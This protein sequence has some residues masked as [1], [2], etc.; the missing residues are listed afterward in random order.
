MTNILGVITEINLYGLRLFIIRSYEFLFRLN[1]CINWL[2]IH[3]KDCLYQKACRFIFTM[4]TI[5]A[6]KSPKFLYKNQNIFGTPIWLSSVCIIM[7]L[8]RCYNSKSQWSFIYLIIFAVAFGICLAHIML[9]YYKTIRFLFV[10][11]CILWL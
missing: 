11:L 2:Y 8:L 3:K 6:L 9:L 5:W 10:F 4:S 1:I 7:W